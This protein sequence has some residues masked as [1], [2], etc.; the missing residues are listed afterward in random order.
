MAGKNQ[1]LELTW[2]NKDKALI[3]TENGKYGYIWVDPHDPR[4]CET[5]TLAVT[6][7]IIGKQ[8]PKEEG[9][10]Y[11]ARADLEPQD[12][13]LLV[14]GESS[15][16]LEALTK[17]PELRDKYFGKVKCVYIDPPFNTAQ[18]FANYEDNLEHSV[19]LTMMRDRLLRLWNLLSDD[20]SIWVHLDDVETHRMR[21]VLDEVF[22]SGNFIAEISWE[23]VAG[24]DNRGIISKTCDF[25]MV[26]AKDRETWRGARN[27]L[28]R[29]AS[30][31]YSNPDNDPRGKWTSSDFSVMY[32]PAENPRLSQR[33][34]LQT[35]SGKILDPP[36]GRVWLYTEP[37]Y[38][39]L[40]QDNRVWFGV[41]GSN[42]P[43]L[44]RFLSEVQDG[45]VP[46]TLWSQ[47]T[48]GT[49]DSAKKELQKTVPTDFPFT[50]PKPERLLERIIHIATNPGDIVLDA[51][52][53]SG[54]TAAVAQKMGRQWVTCEL[55]EDTFNRFTKP[56][57]TKVVNNED[58]GGITY[59]RDRETKPGAILPDK[60]DTDALQDATRLLNAVSK[61]EAITDE[62]AA[63][64]KQV[65]KLFATK[66]S[67]VRNW[68]GGGGFTVAKLSPSCYNYDPEMGYTYLTKAATGETL[69]ASVAANLGF[70]LTPDDPHFDG[71]RNNEHLAVVEG[72]LTEKKVGDLMAY[73]PD[74]HSILFAATVL[75]EG[76]H[77]VVRSYKNGSRAVH[78]PLDLFPYSDEEEN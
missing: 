22:G 1:R 47:K 72:V 61:H 45:L 34:T 67:T 66:P 48:V 6:D 36:P 21:V 10:S 29:Q 12:D 19:W 60:F 54:T 35:P 55:V 74:G 44:K 17:V 46:K 14:L 57:L 25:I 52:A 77:E 3:P 75:D 63:A 65:K 68:R 39:K 4:Y 32:N 16:V 38:E 20:G 69:V 70:Y 2:H 64:I 7:K 23:K 59:T 41:D 26:Y 27:L 76:I 33:Y 71:H 8:A 37:E 11:S 53:G 49:N 30:G 31:M 78:V 18:T 58:E 15:D 42:S 13:N 40:V 43:R 24:R 9:L 56:R 28:P 50:T 51:F 5:H 73:L 62:Q